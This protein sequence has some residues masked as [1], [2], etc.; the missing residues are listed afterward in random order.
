MEMNGLK[1]CATDISSAY[2]YT[3]TR[4]KWYIIAGGPEFGE[5]E[6]EKL[7]ID[8]SFYG[9]RTSGAHFH[10]H[11]GQKLRCMGYMPSQTDPDFWITWH[12]NG[13]YKYI[14]NYVDDVIEDIHSDYML[15]GIDEPEYYLG[16]NVDPLDD[17][18]KDDNVSLALSAQ[19]YVKNVVE[20]FERIFGAELCLQKTPMSNEYH[21]ETNDT[22]LLDARGAS[23]YC[24]LIGSAN[25]AIMLGCFDVQYATQVLSQYSMAPREGH[26]SAMKQV[27]GYLKKFPK[28]KIVVD[29]GY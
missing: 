12:P 15:K 20:Q 8:H 1:V 4:E 29:A 26:L 5:L 16:G 22:P 7:V 14:A 17:T 28:G 10:E 21:P 2:L 9:L 27:F 23:I 6:S 19:T 24:G 18:W 13:H 25:W 11:L 3:K